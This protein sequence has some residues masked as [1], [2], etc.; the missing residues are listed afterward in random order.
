MVLEVKTTLIVKFVI[1]S[2]SMDAACTVRW[3]GDGGR[4]RIILGDHVE[5]APKIC[6]SKDT[7]RILLVNLSKC[8]RREIT[9]SAIQKICGCSFLSVELKVL[10]KNGD[11]SYS[12]ISEFF[13]RL[14]YESIHSRYGFIS[15][16]TIQCSRALVVQ[17]E[18]FWIDLEMLSRKIQFLLTVVTGAGSNLSK[19]VCLNQLQLHHELCTY[20]SPSHPSSHAI[21]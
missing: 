6:S 3:T 21:S 7:T 1:Q 20:P 4:M 9:R 14:E 18:L 11:T 19:P 17:D 8:Q 2:R 10:A 5:V 16:Q 13:S 12:G 15:Q